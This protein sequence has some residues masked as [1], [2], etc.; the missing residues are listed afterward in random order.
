[1]EKLPLPQ[2]KIHISLEGEPF[3]WATLKQKY[4]L[5]PKRYEHAIKQA[6]WIRAGLVRSL[7]KDIIQQVDPSEQTSFRADGSTDLTSDFDVSMAGVQK[8]TVTIAFNEQFEEL[9]ERPSAEVFD[10]NVYGSGPIEEA[11]DAKGSE[12]K[13]NFVCS[14]ACTKKTEKCF[15]IMHL[16]FRHSLAVVN[17]QHAWA[18]ATLLRN[19]SVDEQA[20][21]SARIRSPSNTSS[22]LLQRL[23]TQAEQIY[24]KYPISTDIHTANKRYAD[25]LLQIYQLRINGAKHVTTKEF[26]L[27][28]A[29]AE[30]RGGW[31]AQEAYVTMGPFLHV[32]AN[33]QRQLDLALSQDEYKDSFI[34][35]MAYVL[36][37]FKTGTTCSKAFVI[38][39]KYIARASFA[40]T[41]VFDTSEEEIVSALNQL[42]TESVK[43]RSQRESLISRADKNEHVEQPMI[44]HMHGVSC[45][46][47]NKSRIE[48][49]QW[50]LQHLFL[51]F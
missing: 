44:V 23:F 33:D 46:Q 37:T 1:M 39:A 21:L 20:W 4:L 41:Q 3:E 7:L 35:N 32:V 48:L 25:A 13:G 36:H 49:L 17:N 47:Q 27:Q 51:M 34:E 45:D 42:V 22:R 12:C 30:S 24:T 26:A 6:N 16:R 40:G 2:L 10:T 38:A 9:F 8:E 28:Y 14:S 19:L 15:L 11:N 29:D 18:L 5:N 43:I 31:F 50:I